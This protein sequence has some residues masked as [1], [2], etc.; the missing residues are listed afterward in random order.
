M[1][2]LVIVQ[3]E[4]GKLQTHRR[5]YKARF[6]TNVHLIS[7]KLVDL[8][9]RVTDVNAQYTMLLERV[10]NATDIDIPDL[11]AQ[12][13]HLREQIDALPAAPGDSSAEPL[14]YQHRDVKENIETLRELVVGKSGPLCRSQLRTHT[15]AH[16]KCAPSARRRSSTCWRS[17]LPYARR[18]MQ[19]W[20]LSRHTSKRRYVC[21][22]TLLTDTALN[23]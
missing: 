4:V 18:A 16:Q 2:T 9:E 1:L 17:S 19:H 11:Q 12:V 10:D 23:S 5:K 20:L 13:E 14:L 6:N 15:D 8:D 7:D 21:P 22:A 3:G